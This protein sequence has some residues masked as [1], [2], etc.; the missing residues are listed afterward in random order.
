MKLI[1]ADQEVIG[2]A[3]PHRKLPML[4][5]LGDVPEKESLQEWLSR[6]M[7]Y[8]IRTA[9]KEV[10]NGII[11]VSHI[12]CGLLLIAKKALNKL[13]NSVTKYDFDGE[14]TWFSRGNYYGFFDYMQIGN[15]SVTEDYAFC[16]RWR[17]VGGKVYALVSEEITHVGDIAV[18]GR[19]AD[20]LESGGSSERSL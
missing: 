6:H 14:V 12:G 3:Y 20:R 10:T 5:Q 7:G 19:Y 9:Q 17:D 13:V 2:C 4:E 11:E 18:Q 1:D 15:L 8:S 16:Q